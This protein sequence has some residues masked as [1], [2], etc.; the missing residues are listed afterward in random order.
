[1]RYFT[2]CEQAVLALSLLAIGFLLIDPFMLERARTL[3]ASAC[4]FFKL[5]TDL[6]RSHWMLIPR[7]RS[8][9]SPSSCGA[10]ISAFATGLAMD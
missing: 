8:S 6:G 2:L 1:M 7:R 5:V 4:D 3:S 10:G 9:S